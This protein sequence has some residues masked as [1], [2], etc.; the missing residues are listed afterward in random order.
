MLS[1]TVFENAPFSIFLSEFGKP[2][3]LS[4]EP[5]NA[6]AASL[7]LR[8]YHHLRKEYPFVSSSPMYFSIVT[9]EALSVYL[10]SLAGLGAV[11]IIV[12]TI[13]HAYKRN[14]YY[15]DKRYQRRGELF[16]HCLAGLT[17]EAGA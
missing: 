11:N 6:L 12:K 1:N 2:I 8:V 9:D 5:L 13:A 3:L 4:G 17:A 16:I 7:L 14:T 10:K 15:S